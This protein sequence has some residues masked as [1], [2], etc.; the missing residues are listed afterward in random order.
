MALDIDSRSGL[1]AFNITSQKG[2]IKIQQKKRFA[3]YL[4][5]KPYLQYRT[6]QKKHK[7]LAYNTDE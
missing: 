5:S 6:T 1:H 7:A 3:R 4:L 2:V